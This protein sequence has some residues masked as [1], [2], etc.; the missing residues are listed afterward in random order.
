MYSDLATTKHSFSDVGFRA[1]LFAAPR[2]CVFFR[3]I[4]HSGFLV[5]FPVALPCLSL[6]N[7]FRLCAHQL[8]HFFAI[9]SSV[10]RRLNW[11]LI[12]L[13]VTTLV[14]AALVRIVLLVQVFLLRDSIQSIYFLSARC[15]GLVH[16][17]FDLPHPLCLFYSKLFAFLVP[18]PLVHLAF[19]QASQS[20]DDC[21]FFLRPVW[22]LIEL[23]IQLHQLLA[24]LSFALADD[25]VKLSGIRVEIVATP[26]LRLRLLSNDNFLSLLLC[27][28]D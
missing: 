17:V 6:L 23:G 18:P 3:L 14:F 20:T 25:A 21:E 4:L 12:F 28:A 24:A 22:V 1:D 19:T 10:I 9:A 26:L 7:C 5:P 2:L 15:I 16:L 13:G 8:F 27:R 11:C